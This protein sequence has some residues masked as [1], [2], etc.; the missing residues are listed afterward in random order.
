MAGRKGRIPAG[1][2]RTRQ[3]LPSISCSRRLRHRRMLVRYRYRAH[4]DGGQV[5][6]RMSVKTFRANAAKLYCGMHRLPKLDSAAGEPP[7][8]FEFAHGAMTM[9]E[10]HLYS[11]YKSR[12]SIAVQGQCFGESTGNDASRIHRCV[13]DHSSI[14]Y[15]TKTT[16]ISTGR[17]SQERPSHT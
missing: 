10:R 12:I 13:Y 5:E 8:S 15:P 9:G 3:Q 16:T 17:S 1:G 6:N 4:G 7:P 2:D 14:L 11:F